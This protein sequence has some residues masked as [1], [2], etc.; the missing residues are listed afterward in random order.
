MIKWRGQNTFK[1]V[2]WNAEADSYKELYFEL[3]DRD[4]ISIEDGYPDE[5]FLLD[6]VGLKMADFD[7]HEE[8]YD[9]E[10]Q[11]WFEKVTDGLELTEDDYKYIISQEKGNAYYQEFEEVDE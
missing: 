10:Y 1:N 5:I 4:I 11:A 7:E 9:Y 6:K 3:I 2:T 8:E